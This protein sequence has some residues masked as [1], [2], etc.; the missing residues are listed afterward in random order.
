MEGL[1]AKSGR[2][3]QQQQGE[4]VQTTT[5]TNSK[6]LAELEDDSRILKRAKTSISTA[7]REL[8][9]PISFELPIDPV[10]A[11]DGRV[12]ERA[13]IERHVRVHVGALR[14]PATNEEMDGAIL[15]HAPHIRNIIQQLID[16]GAMD[17]DLADTWMERM[18]MKKK[19][20][21]ARARAGKGDTMAMCNLGIW[22]AEGANELPR[23]ETLALT[24]FECAA[25]RGSEVGIECKKKLEDKQLVRATMREAEGGDT[26][27][28]VSLGGWLAYG[29]KGL[30]KNKEEA[31]RWFKMA[32]D[33]RDVRGMACTGRRLIAGDGVKRNV[34]SGIVLLTTAANRGS[35]WACYK[36]GKFY[37]MGTAGFDKDD[38]EA[39]YWLER[40]VSGSC[41]VKHLSDAGK[42]ECLHWL[43]SIDGYS[44]DAPP[45]VVEV[46]W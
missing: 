24:W 26:E 23:N 1:A 40:A 3:M 32:A 35:D 45:D 31:F 14:S 41:S 30:R 10:T 34:S 36:L 18:A 28:M 6:R 33:C 25:A 7:A 17:D 44:S 11:M 12:Y 29:K 15:L 5:M 39:E 37:F 19:V 38:K 16:S 22:Y 9:C 27:A 46:M 43:E 4:E 21:D 13:E 2:A 42:K 20:D 8:V